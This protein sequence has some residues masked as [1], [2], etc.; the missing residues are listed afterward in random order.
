[1]ASQVRLT[2]AQGGRVLGMQQV[3]HILPEGQVHCGEGAGRDSL[4]R[5]H[6]LASRVGQ[7]TFPVGVGVGSAQPYHALAK[8]GQQP[9]SGAQGPEPLRGWGEDSR[10]GPSKGEKG[11]REAPALTELSVS[12]CRTTGLEKA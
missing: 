6:T 3:L 7:L 10:P 2:V 11:P 5:P 8:G 4:P 9:F 12:P 1:M